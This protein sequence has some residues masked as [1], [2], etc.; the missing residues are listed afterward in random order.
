MCHCA[1]RKAFV[2][3]NVRVDD[4][5]Q[6]DI[7]ELVHEVDGCEGCCFGPP[8]N[9]NT[10]APR[11]DADDD[12]IG[13]GSGCGLDEVRI[14]HR[15]RCDNH[16]GC[17]GIHPVMNLFHVAYCTADL[18]QAA[19]RADDLFDN[20]VIVPVVENGIQINHMQ[21]LRALHHQIVGGFHRIDI[22]DEWTLDPVADQ[23]DKAAFAQFE[24]GINDHFSPSNSLR[25]TDIAP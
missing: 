23:I 16:A 22:I 25:C 4:R 11:I 5:G 8:I 9:D 13:I 1:V 3:I 2:P 12:G 24:I 15:C 6:S 21:P 17:A 20:I 7:F 18:N 19:Y 10:P 14:F